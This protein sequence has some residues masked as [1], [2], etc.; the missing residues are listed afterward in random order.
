M[1]A[2]DSAVARLI[3][4]DDIRNVLT[5]Y[6]RA[7]DRKDGELLRDVYW[8]D[9]YDDHILYTGGVDGLVEH[10]I[11]FTKDMP[12]HHFIGNILIELDDADHAFVETYYHAY[13]LVPD[14]EAD[15]SRDLVLLGRYLDS[16]E[17][18]DGKWKIA[19]RICTVDAY[20]HQVATSDFSQGILAPAKHIGS[21]RPSD[22]LYTY[23]P[24]ALHRKGLYA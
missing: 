6:C 21:G 23:H 24:A 5:H 8:E 15:V 9:A 10:A 12:T 1:P 14:A 4:K 13:H 16:F 19:R 2:S 11:S 17:R 22:P 18:R 7:V 3:A 20:T